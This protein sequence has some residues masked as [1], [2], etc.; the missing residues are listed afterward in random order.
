M[1]QWKMGSAW[2]MECKQQKDREKSNGAVCQGGCTF[3]TPPPALG[4]EESA[5]FDGMKTILC[6]THFSFPRSRAACHR[7]QSKYFSFTKK[8]GSIVIS[9]IL[10]S[11]IKMSSREP[12]RVLNTWGTS[13][14]T[15]GKPVKVTNDKEAPWEILT[16]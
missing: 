6:C 8:N 11:Q 9:L 15:S 10:A 5:C 14:Q 3:P 2:R 13:K 1:M 12:H 7:R 4:N 16:S